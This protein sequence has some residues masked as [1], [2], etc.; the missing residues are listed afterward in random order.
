MLDNKKTKYYAY[1]TKKIISENEVG[2]NEVINIESKGTF[3][4]SEDMLCRI[5]EALKDDKPLPQ[6]YSRQIEQHRQ[7]LDVF[8]FENSQGKKY[9]VLVY[10]S[11]ELSQDPTI[12]QIIN[13]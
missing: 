4:Y 11:D 6:D 5:T 2:I 9:F 13:R 7:Y 8:S 3:G 1:L 12:V 10:D